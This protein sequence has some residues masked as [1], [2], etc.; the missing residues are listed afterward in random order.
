MWTVLK[1]ETFSAAVCLYVASKT[2]LA[3][4]DLES[5]IKG[6]NTILL[7][8]LPLSTLFLHK[9]FYLRNAIDIAFAAA[10]Q[11]KYKI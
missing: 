7:S 10:N 5:K 2:P 1:A 11:F 4:R 9:V 6:V 8:K 3:K